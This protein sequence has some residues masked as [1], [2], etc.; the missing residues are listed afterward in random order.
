MKI[1]CILGMTDNAVNEH[2]TMPDSIVKGRNGKT[3]EILNTDA[4]GD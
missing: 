2:A 4:E 3:V 1:T